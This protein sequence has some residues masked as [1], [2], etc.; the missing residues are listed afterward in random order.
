[1]NV[2]VL[3]N[4]SYLICL[5]PFSKKSHDELMLVIERNR[6]ISSA[7]RSV[8]ESRRRTHAS[9][10]KEERLTR[11]FERLRL[12]QLELD[13]CASEPST[14]DADAKAAKHKEK[15]DSTASALR[16]Q[17]AETGKC[18]DDLKQRE[19]EL[20]SL[21]LKIWKE[22]LDHRTLALAFE[23]QARTQ[24]VI[25]RVE[26]RV[27]EREMQAMEVSQ[28]HEQ[29]S[30][31]ANA[32]S[33]AEQFSSRVVIA[34]STIASVKLRLLTLDPTINGA[35][36]R[37]VSQY[38]VAQREAEISVLEE[39]KLQRLIGKTVLKIVQLQGTGDST[40]D[41]LERAYLE[42]RDELQRSL[43][44]H[45]KKNLLVGQA[46]FRVDALIKRV[47]VVRL[48]LSTLPYSPAEQVQEL[49]HII[50][51]VNKFLTEF[52]QLGEVSSEADCEIDIAERLSLLEKSILRAYIRLARG[53]QL[54]PGKAKKFESKCESIKSLL[55]KQM[56]E[57]AANMLRWDSV[58][59]TASEE[60]MELAFS[61]ATQRFEL[62]SSFKE[63][64]KLCIDALE[65]SVAHSS[66][67]K[68]ELSPTSQP[69]IHHQSE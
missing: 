37:L 41:K 30:L 4:L 10:T 26:L 8:N 57:E 60:E 68:F 20:R 65:V 28:V 42:S 67:T 64:L 66:G 63:H 2:A 39:S 32:L 50:E 19:K 21:C 61:V 69:S 48:L 49:R 23:D 9:L 13:R 51:R 38:E 14:K 17:I 27:L 35:Y 24:S 29:R 31:Y 54:P 53:G 7:E 25:D 47:C 46:L 34:K 45:K 12:R 11:R 18:L 6:R 1:M 33:L 55:I 36:S 58:L 43:R 3:C 52:L 62:C 16:Q 22:E 56:V 15:V 59:T 5:A 40:N 44:Q